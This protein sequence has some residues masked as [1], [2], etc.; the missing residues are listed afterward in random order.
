MVK[1]GISE[2]AARIHQDALV[3]DMTLPWTSPTELNI[4]AFELKYACIESYARHGA[5]MVSVTVASDDGIE[6]TIRMLAQE[7]RF[8]LNQNDKYV[9]VESAEDILR[10]QKEGKL[11]IGFHFQGSLPVDRDVALVELY[12]KLGVRHMLMA[13]NQKNF[14][15]DGVHERTDAGLSSFGVEMIREMNRVGM[16]VDCAHSGYRTSMDALE[17]SEETTIF[18]H[19]NAKAVYDHPRNIRDDQAKAC[20][21]SGGVIGVNGINIFVNG[22]TAT[23]EDIFQHIDYF[24]NLVGPDHVGLGLDHVYDPASLIYYTKLQAARWPESGGYN[25]SDVFFYGPD[26][27]PQ[28]TQVMLDHGYDEKTI[29]GILGQN[30][31]RVCQQ[32]WK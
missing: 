21:D 26:G 30:W 5:N 32:V 17:V 11:A 3:W 2:E 10:A 19:A 9:L 4:A 29:R 7:R 13:Y 1:W 12:Y 22:S 31:L 16:I 23:P 25:R 18:S 28:L 15:G 8:F 6:K 20:A 27:L 14:V 24:A